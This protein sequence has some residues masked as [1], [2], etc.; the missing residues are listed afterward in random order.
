MHEFLPE[1]YRKKVNEQIRKREEQLG[2]GK[3]DTYPRYREIV[4][5]IK[6]MKEALKLF[7]ESLKEY[8]EETDD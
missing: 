8:G 4:G 7:G 6:G 1:D 5:Q 2:N 3:A